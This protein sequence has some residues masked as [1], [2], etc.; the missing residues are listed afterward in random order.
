[1]S[2]HTRHLTFLILSQ[3]IYLEKNERFLELGCEPSIWIIL[4]TWSCPW[5][6]FPRRFH[7]PLYCGFGDVAFL[8]ST[9]L[10]HF[11]NFLSGWQPFCNLSQ[12]TI[13]TSQSATYCHD[14]ELHEILG[15]LESVPV[16]SSLKGF[17]TSSKLE[18]SIL[19]KQRRPLL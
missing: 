1:M 7:H 18:W 16:I 14:C 11:Q 13:A 12:A 15:I 6:C 5:P 19:W 2:H 3:F 8:K 17:M 4:L 9:F 10:C